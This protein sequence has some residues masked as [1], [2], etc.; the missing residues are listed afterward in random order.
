MNVEI[1]SSFTSAIF[2][3]APLQDQNL[4]TLHASKRQAAS[5]SPDWSKIPCICAP[6]KQPA[7][8]ISKKNR[9]WSL[10]TPYHPST[11]ITCHV[12]I[13]FIFRANVR[14]F[15]V[16]TY[17]HLGRYSPASYHGKPRPTSADLHRIYGFFRKWIKCYSLHSLWNQDSTWKRMVGSPGSFWDGLFSGAISVLGSVILTRNLKITCL[18]RKLHLPSTFILGSMLTFSCVFV[19]S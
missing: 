14:S 7:K 10:I 11:S 6:K 17:W 16:F 5:E 18:R 9:E 19:A 3:A 2:V 13:P 12:M 4:S 8:R 15:E 1:H